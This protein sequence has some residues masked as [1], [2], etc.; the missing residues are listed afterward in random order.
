[1]KGNTFNQ[2]FEE[3]SRILR[4]ATQRNNRDIQHITF[5]DSVIINTKE[6]N[7]RNL[8]DLIWAIAEINYRLLTELDIPICG[9]VSKG[10]FSRYEDKKNGNVIIAGA[11]II[12]AY[13]YEQRQNWI[14]VMLSPTVLRDNPNLFQYGSFNPPRDDNEAKEIKSCFPWPLLIRRYRS[15]PFKKLNDFDDQ[16][17]DGFVIVPQNSGCQEPAEL[18]K[19]LD[20]YKNRLDPLMA[21]AS[22]PDQ[23]NKYRE[24]ARWIEEVKN[25]WGDVSNRRVWGKVM[26]RSK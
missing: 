1:M 7:E 4:K 3:Y 26:N 17:Y 19:D 6:A 14:G 2:K 24:T 25:Y 23:Q 8:L 12:D 21:F 15:I 18:I 13:Q 11:P 10:P 20:D 5:S 9:S 16:N 22:E